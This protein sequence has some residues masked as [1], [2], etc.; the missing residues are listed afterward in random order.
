[1]SVYGR[2]IRAVLQRYTLSSSTISFKPVSNIIKPFTATSRCYS[3]SLQEK[4]HQKSI[5][6]PATFWSEAASRDLEWEKRFD[7]DVYNQA[8]LIH[9]KWFKGGKISIVHNAIH[10]HINEGR[11]NHLAFLYDN[12]YNGVKESITYRQLKDRVEQLAE[13][14]ASLGVSQGDTMPMIPEAIYGM[15]ATAYLGAIH[16]VVFGGFAAN[17]LA[18]RIQDSKPKVILYGTCGIEPTRVIPYKPLVDEA[19]KQTT[20]KVPYRLV[21]QR[22][23]GPKVE[24]SEGELDWVKTVESVKRSGKKQYPKPVAMD[25]TDPLYLLYTSGSTGVPKGVVRDTGG[26]TVAL[27]YAMEH[28]FNLNIGDVMFTASDCGWV[29]GHS[30]IVYGPLLAGCTSVIYEGK[31][32]LPRDGPGAFWRIVEEY[33]VKCLFTAPTAI[34]AIKREDPEGKIMRKYK[35]DTL[36]NL[37][38]AGERSDPDTVTHFQNLLNIPIRDNYWQTESGWPITAACAKGNDSSSTRGTLV[39][40]GSAGKPVPG[41]NVQV[42]AKKHDTH[43]DHMNESPIGEV[44][45][46]TSKSFEQ[47]NPGELGNLVVKLPLPPGCFTTLWKNEEGYVKSYFSRFPGYYD[48]TDAGLV[49]SDNYVHVMGR[50]DDVLNVAGHRLSAGGMEEI[51]SSHESVAECAVIGMKDELKGEKPVGFVVLKKGAG[52]GDV[53]E[54]LVNLV[55][56]K[57]GPFACFHHLFIC[58]RL[59]KTRSGKI[60]RKTMRAISNGEAYDVPATIEDV[61][62]LKEIEKL[63]GNK[64]ARL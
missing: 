31:P 48:L 39:R 9:P 24:L 2:S 8:D 27:K 10:R 23:V 57:I 6:D 19:L 34:R 38:L 62:V 60:L 64:K 52:A 17:E 26:Y 33:K 32:I 36:E 59:P 21:Y 5:K 15:L 14:L 61:D 22:D 37:F 11:G 3:T 55:R 56:T 29:V 49:D 41:F 25:S 44:H 18:K 51:V 53:R 7:D 47:A 43:D 20:Y 13:T 45:M 4:L 63:F 12:G 46:P 58:E 30:F 42:L 54:E 35:I 28:I 40:V 50:T 16:S 1:M